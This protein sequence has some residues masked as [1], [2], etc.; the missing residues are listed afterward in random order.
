MRFAPKSYMYEIFKTGGFG[1]LFEDQMYPWGHNALLKE[2]R[3]KLGLKVGAPKDVKDGDM[4]R[5]LRWHTK[6]VAGP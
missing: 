5:L 4:L 6:R 3:D 1:L 2:V